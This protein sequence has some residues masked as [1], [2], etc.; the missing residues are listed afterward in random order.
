MLINRMEEGQ[1]IDVLDQLK[2]KKNNLALRYDLIGLLVV[3]LA[4]LVFIPELNAFFESKHQ[5]GGMGVYILLILLA[6]VFIKS[7]RKA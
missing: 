3:F 7:S 5:L 2:H 4:T 1:K 6:L